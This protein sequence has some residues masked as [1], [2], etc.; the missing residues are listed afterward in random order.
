MTETYTY[1]GID[2][3]TTT[4]LIARAQ[5]DADN[6]ISIKVL[7]IKQKDGSGK[8][9]EMSYLPSLAYLK[10][11]GELV[12]GLEAQNRG[13]ENPS[14]LVRAVKRQMGRRILLPEIN[15]Q[16]FQI[17]AEYLKKALQEGKKQFPRDKIIFTVTV[18]A[19]FTSNQRADTLRALKI[20]CDEPGIG[21]PY[22]QKEDG[23]LF[24]SEPVAAMLAFLNKQFE[25]SKEVRDLDFEKEHR[26]VIY[27]IGGGTLDLT[28]VFIEP[29]KRPVQ[30]LADLTIVVEEI[31]KYNP[32]GGEEFDLKLAEEFS[33][34]LMEKFPKLQESVLT[35][36]ERAGVKLQLM[37]FAKKE[38]E[39]MSQLIA[40][41]SNALFG[42]AEDKLFYFPEE[43]PIMI[44]GKP[45][46]LEGE[47]TIA[48]YRD[49]V[50]D[51]TD[52]N[53]SSQKNLIAPLRDLLEKTGDNPQDLSGILIVG[54]MALLPLVRESI[55][56]YWKF[57]DKVWTFNPSDHA[58]V[59]GAAVYS[60]L[61]QK[62]PEFS[63]KEYAADAYYVWLAEGEFDLIL[64]S[65]ADE[66]EP[67]R[68]ILKSKS[69]RLKIQIFAGEDPK[70]Q[71]IEETSLIYQG[72]LSIDLKKPYDEGTPV[73]IKML[74]TNQDNQDHTKIPWVYVWL[75]DP[76]NQKMHD[77]DYRFTGF[78]QEAEDEKDI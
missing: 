18:P 60:C 29:K 51:L 41:Q 44:A 10:E 8:E 74:Y 4:T 63:L 76:A 64:P 22:P 32:F 70:N 24:I 37:N 26:I 16:P 68:Y 3:G 23:S 43:K 14:R 69:K 66:G 42:D 15:K 48:E 45:Y 46:S 38:K 5:E 12:V 27:D 31:S 17:S 28:I 25:L 49:I 58:V 72:G 71:L 34:R 50:R 21:I 33:K 56:K 55:I 7:P 47:L 52:I 57:D 67:K 77:F 40:D 19:S 13:S 59:A 39:K 35:P 61:R 62:Y 30:K 65:K 53:S 2:L 9:K 75:K 11:D 1:I 6:K 36:R 73:W 78:T 20:A 54:G